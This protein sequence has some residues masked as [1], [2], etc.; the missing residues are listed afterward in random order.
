MISDFLQYLFDGLSAGAI[1]SLLALGLVIV[2]RGTGH[3]NFAQGEM[4]M[5]SAFL[6]W[7]LSD[8]WLP[9]WVAVFICAAFGFALGAVVERVIIRPI[10]QRSIFAVGVAAIGLLLGI[11]ALAPFIWK[12]THPEG[13]ES[14]FPKKPT[15]FVT[16]GGA[17]WRYENIGVLVVMLIVAGLLYLLFQKTKLGLAMRAV[18]SNPESAPLAGI[19]TGQVLMM[20]WGL[21]AAAGAIGGCMVA[22]LRGNVEPSMMLAIFFSATAAAMLGGFDSLLGAVVAGLLLGVIES[23]GAGYQPDVIGPELKGSL[24]LIIILI[25]L[26]FRPSG[27]FGSKRVERV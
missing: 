3:L 12:V 5:L 13:F 7:W 2:Y 1:Y 17:H 14:L 22:T 23:M 26:L 11:N 25:V 10:G 16:I 6:A 18:A 8:N 20:S 21:A 15:D 19:K 24:S 27:L 9:I 4:A